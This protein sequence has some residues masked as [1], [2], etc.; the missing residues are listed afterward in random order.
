MTAEFD[1]RRS[2]ALSRSFLLLLR[3]V[4]A[5]GGEHFLQVLLGSISQGIDCG[6][7]RQPKLRDRILHRDR[8]GCDGAALDEPVALE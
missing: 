6:S 8:H 2:T 7:E 3:V 4:A 1:A 5:L